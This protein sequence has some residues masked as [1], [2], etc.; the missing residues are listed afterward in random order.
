LKTSKRVF[1]EVFLLSKKKKK[2][3]KRRTKGKTK[4]LELGF[5]SF[6]LWEQ[7]VG[8]LIISSRFC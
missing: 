3:K 5:E 6:E 2:K 1:E 8:N 7:Q 4:S